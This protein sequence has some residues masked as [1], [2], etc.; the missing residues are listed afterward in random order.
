MGSS[1]LSS[2]NHA[3]RS[4]FALAL[5][6][7]DF[8]AASKVSQRVGMF[9]ST[10]GRTVMA[11]SRSGLVSAR[12]TSR[13]CR[14]CR[15]VQGFRA[16]RAYRRLQAASVLDDGVSDSN[17]GCAAFFRRNPAIQRKVSASSFALT[18]ARRPTNFRPLQTRCIASH[19]PRTSS[20][21]SPL[22]R[23]RSRA[24]AF[25]PCARPRL[26]KSLLVRR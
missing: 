17:Y 26:G 5:R 9:A 7:Q 2:S 11:A 20:A 22:L 21:P 25:C 6:G 1:K 18:A 14:P 16:G 23:L 24:K 12:D 19:S 13:S 15:C 8:G 3:A 10:T 4:P